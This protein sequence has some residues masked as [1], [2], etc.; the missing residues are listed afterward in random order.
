[1]TLAVIIHV[2]LNDPVTDAHIHPSTP[3]MY[4][5]MKLC[6]VH[7]Y[8]VS[9]YT[10]LRYHNITSDIIISRTRYAYSQNILVLSFILHV[11]SIRTHVC[12]YTI[13]LFFILTC[14]VSTLL[15]SVFAVCV[16]N[17]SFYTLHISTRCRYTCNFE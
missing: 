15:V 16:L 9:L 3:V 10:D 7:I 6:I 1:M 14:T 17:K 8:F 5:Y 4:V 2:I 13:C 12:M 11:L